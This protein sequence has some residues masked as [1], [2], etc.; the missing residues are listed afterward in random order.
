MR[1]L[2]FTLWSSIIII[3]LLAYTNQEIFF[4]WSD[5]IYYKIVNFQHKLSSNDKSHHDSVGYMSRIISSG[6]EAGY[7]CK[8]K[9]LFAASVQQ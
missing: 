1:S 3:G 6:K 7:S 8:N 2:K 9:Q 5:Y 4:G